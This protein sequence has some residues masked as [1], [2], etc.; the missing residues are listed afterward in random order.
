MLALGILGAAVASGPQVDEGI[1]GDGVVA[2]RLGGV[3]ICRYFPN[4]IRDYGPPE[5]GNS[6]RLDQWTRKARQQ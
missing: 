2:G 1:L 5:I 6:A 4:T 3:L